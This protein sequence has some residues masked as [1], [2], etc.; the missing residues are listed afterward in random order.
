M[1]FE[2]FYLSQ[3]NIK[4]L[5]NQYRDIIRQEHGDDIPASFIPKQMEIMKQKILQFL[6]D[7]NK[8]IIENIKECNNETIIELKKYFEFQKSINTFRNIPQSFPQNNISPKESDFVPPVTGGVLLGQAPNPVGSPSLPSFPKPMKTREDSPT[9]IP[10][11]LK[12][13]SVKKKVKFD[14]KNNLENQQEEDLEV[15]FKKLSSAY[16]SN[17]D[18]IKPELPNVQPEFVQPELVA[19]MATVQPELVKPEFIIPQTTETV[20]IDITEF[21]DLFKQFLTTQKDIQESFLNNIKKIMEPKETK[22]V[23]EPNKVTMAFNLSGNQSSIIVPLGKKINNIQSIEIIGAKIPRS[24]YLINY[25]NNTLC[26]SESKEYSLDIKIPIGDYSINQIL[27]NIIN[28]MNKVGK[29]KYSYKLD[30]HTHRITVISDLSCDDHIFTLDMTKSGLSAILGFE[31]KL[32]ENDKEYTGSYRYNLNP[33]SKI[34]LYFDNINSEIPFGSFYLDSPS[35]QE[36]ILL[37]QS[38]V[39]I[40][41]TSHGP[42]KKIFGRIIKELTDLHVSF[43]YD[44]C[45]VDWEITLEITFLY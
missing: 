20:K 19:P 43:N 36:N 18:T 31:E 9:D 30:P 12:P 11:E 42:M 38:D 34:D 17:I 33:Q 32:F 8:N 1:S 25:S 35:N 21:V 24:Q 28:A 23:K 7:K 14:D 4:I 45:G 39:Y 5:F 13:I 22:E 3:N 2:E 41:R 16:S 40:Y 44:F 15:K 26:F 27:D 29:S 10:E 6:P 37:G